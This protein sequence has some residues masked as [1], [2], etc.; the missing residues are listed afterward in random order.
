M[1]EKINLLYKI[2]LIYNFL[3]NLTYLNCFKIDK[4]NLG[5][6]GLDDIKLVDEKEINEYMDDLNKSTFSYLKYNEKIFRFI[7]S[8]C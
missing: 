5:E 2:N 6:I 1:G 4:I 3:Y 8:N 7:Y